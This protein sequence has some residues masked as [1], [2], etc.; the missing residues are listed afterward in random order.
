[1]DPEGEFDF[2][3]W[4]IEDI[5]EGDVEKSESHRE[6]FSLLNESFDVI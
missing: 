4:V 2:V 6:V 5:S 1:M 3:V